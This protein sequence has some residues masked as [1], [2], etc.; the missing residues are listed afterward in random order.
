MVLTGQNPGA[1]CSHGEDAAQFTDAKRAALR[2]QALA[3]LR[4]DLDAW[5]GRLDKEP[6]KACPAVAEKMQHWLRDPDFNGVRGPEA[7]AK[8][9]EAERLGW[10]KLWADVA[11]TLGRA[12]DKPQ[13]SRAGDKKP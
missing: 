13:H 8:L 1:G 6:E 11:E 10:Q 2:Q 12:A 3:W 4:A 5:R 7:L 9:P